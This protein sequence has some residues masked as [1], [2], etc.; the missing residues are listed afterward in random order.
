MTT[1]LQQVMERLKHDVTVD[2]KGTE[3]WFLNGKRHR[4]DGP[5]VIYA[6]GTQKWYRNDLLHRED[7]PAIVWFDG[8]HEWWINGEFIKDNVN[9]S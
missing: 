4:E 1:N 6:N 7:G 5:A 3:R 9:D 8:T 2:E